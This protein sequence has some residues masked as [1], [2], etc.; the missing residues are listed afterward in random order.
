MKRLIL[1]V[2]LM[3]SACIPA[4]DSAKFGFVAEGE[5]DVSIADT[6][7]T[8]VSD[9]GAD[10]G[11]TA[12]QEPD[13][14]PDLVEDATNGCV[15]ENT[16]ALCARIAV[17]CGTAR[18]QDNCSETRDVYCGSCVFGTGCASGTCIET[19]CRDTMDN[20]GDGMGDCADPD[21]SGQ[22][23]SRTDDNKRCE[24]DGQCT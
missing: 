14:T 2:S 19:E 4:G 9:S 7:D 6:G 16:D 23:C 20:D 24:D 11:N 12:M 5:A 22:K 10:A 13:A 17:Q 21:C 15:S 1:S 18:G 8:T 3:L